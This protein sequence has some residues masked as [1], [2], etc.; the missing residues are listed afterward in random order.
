[1]REV[2]EVWVVMHWSYTQTAGNVFWPIFPLSLRFL[3]FASRKK[4]LI[5]D[6]IGLCV[7]PCVRRK[8]QLG[9]LAIEHTIWSTFKL[10]K[11]I[12]SNPQLGH[13][14][15]HVR[16]FGYTVYNIYRQNSARS[17][18]R[19]RYLQY[20]TR[21]SRPKL[22]TWVAQLRKKSYYCVL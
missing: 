10:H 14:A 1:M 3:L 16:S 7:C 18:L 9:T 17:Q 8:T 15:T 6:R 12:S 19:K 21:H 4:H 11:M 13:T 20:C 5:P 2:R 22:R